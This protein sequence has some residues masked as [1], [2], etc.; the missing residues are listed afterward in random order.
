MRCRQAREVSLL[1]INDATK[2]VVNFV[3]TTTGI[4]PAM[5]CVRHDITQGSWA[6]RSIHHTERLAWFSVVPSRGLAWLRRFLSVGGSC[7]IRVP[8]DRFRVFL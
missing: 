1:L 7:P 2:S 5:P 8:V 3:L 4:V 6:A